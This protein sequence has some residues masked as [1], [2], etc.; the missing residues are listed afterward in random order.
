MKK[1]GSKTNEA[2]IMQKFSNHLDQS[3]P[4][5]IVLL[6]YEVASTKKWNFSVFFNLKKNNNNNTQFKIR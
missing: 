2:E 3:E 5:N 6:K 1:R 4:L